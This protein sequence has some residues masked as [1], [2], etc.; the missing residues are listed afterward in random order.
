MTLDGAKNVIIRKL[1]FLMNGYR[2]TSMSIENKSEN[3]IVE[4]CDM[5]NTWYALGVGISGGSRDVVIR[6]NFLHAGYGNHRVYVTDA[7]DVT[8]TG[9]RMEVDWEA[10]IYGHSGVNNLTISHNDIYESGSPGIRLNLSSDSVYIL[11][12]RIHK[13][14]IE[15]VLNN[16]NG[17]CVIENNRIIS[18]AS[19]GIILSTKRCRVA[20]NYITISGINP[21]WGIQVSDSHNTSI[22]FNTVHVLNSNIGSSGIRVAGGTSLDIRNNIFSNIGGG[23]CAYIANMPLSGIWDYNNYHNLYQR[24][25][26]LNGQTYPAFTSWYGAIS[27][28]SHGLSCNPFFTNDSTLVPHQILLNNAGIMIPGVVSDI[29][30]VKRD[31]VTPDTGASEFSPCVNDAGVNA[32]TFPS[33]PANSGNQDVRVLLQNQGTNTLGSVRIDWSVNGV[34]QN[35]FNWTGSLGSRKNTEIKIGTVSLQP[36][37]IYNIKAWTSGPNGIKDCDQYNDTVMSPR[38]FTKLCGTYTIGGINPN[39]RTINEAVHVLTDAGIS[40]PVVFKVRDGSYLEQV[41]INPIPGSSVINTV[42]FESESG[43]SSKVTLSNNAGARIK[44]KWSKEYFY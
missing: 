26:F 38:I 4:N 39:F 21:Y 31:P 33:T 37:V 25:G 7:E 41:E 28:E 29:D 36:G 8:I 20:N 9:N 24:T 2:A 6:N 15:V 19:S 14:S 44:N 10:A 18:S 34:V 32:V 22:I 27:G 3:I 1:G 5:S 13:G 43:D 42:T 17:W 23:Y 30:G 16:E 40:C 12:N 35:S 11:G